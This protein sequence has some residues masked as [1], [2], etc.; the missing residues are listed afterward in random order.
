MNYFVTGATGFIGRFLLARLLSRKDSRVFAL[1]RPGSEYKLDAMRRR[2]NV[3]PERLVA[4]KGDLTKKVLGVSK[5]D[6]DDL[7][8]AKINHFFHLAAIYDLTAD[9]NQQRYTNIEGTRNALRLAEELN[10]GCFHHISSVAA[11]GLYDG[12][13][14]EDMF[15]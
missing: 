14:R 4:I 7:A 1:I 8:A 6:R 10:A 15:D 12:T 3:E 11:A 13:F 2:L 9:E 5:R